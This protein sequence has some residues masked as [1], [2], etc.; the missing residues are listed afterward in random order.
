MDPGPKGPAAILLASCSSTKWT[1]LPP[2][3]APAR[4]EI[5]RLVLKDKPLE[6]IDYGNPGICGTA[7]LR[8]R[9][10]RALYSIALTLIGICALVTH[11]AGHRSLAG[12]FF[13]AGIIVYTWIANLQRRCKS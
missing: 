13:V 1:C 8:R 2:P 10:F 11:E 3:D 12:G 7:S 9:R 4:A 5:F 6:D